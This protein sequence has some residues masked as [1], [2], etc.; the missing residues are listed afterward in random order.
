MKQQEIDLNE[1]NIE[2]LLELRNRTV[3]S[4]NQKARRLR[5]WEKK[6]NETHQEHPTKVANF[7]LKTYEKENQL[8]Y[9]SNRG[10]EKVKNAT[11][12]DRREI[13]HEIA[14][15]RQFVNKISSS[16][17]QYT[18]KGQKTVDTIFNR[19]GLKM[20]VDDLYTFFESP[21]YKRW[22]EKFNFSSTQ[23]LVSIGNQ[24]RDNDITLKQFLEQSFI[25]KEADTYEVKEVENVTDAIPFEHLKHTRQRKK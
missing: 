11:E 13:L 20:T 5:E 16:G 4:A 24:L 17:T 3:K 1:L 6:Y 22:S 23:S 7:A 8:Q 12:K 25:H 9:G 18:K 10:R 21:Q 14:I 19:Y 2:S 15:A